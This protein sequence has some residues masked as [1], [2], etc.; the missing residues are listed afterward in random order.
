MSLT[1]AQYYVVSY[2]GQ[3]SY[4]QNRR[5]SCP[6]SSPV[7]WA[8]LALFTHRRS[9]AGWWLIVAFK[10]SRERSSPAGPPRTRRRCCTKGMRRTFPGATK[11]RC[12]AAMGRVVRDLGVGPDPSQ[13]LAQRTACSMTTASTTHCCDLTSTSDLPSG[14]TR[15]VHCVGCG[16]GELPL[17]QNDG[18]ISYQIGC[19]CRTY[20]PSSSN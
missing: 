11:Q 14:F 7:R 8:F 4:A 9:I 6:R 5:P 18:D 17:S 3:A 10:G 16:Q 2:D 19:I 1:I 13:Q 15:T 20:E 12:Q